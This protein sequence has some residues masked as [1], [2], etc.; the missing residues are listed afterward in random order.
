MKLTHLALAAVLGASVLAAQAHE[1]VYL[2]T[3]DGPSEAPTNNS[4]GTGTAKITFDLDLVTMRVEASFAGLTG[5]VSAA[6]IH[7]C[8]TNA[9]AGTAGV[10]TITP[11]FTG[12]PSGVTAGTYDVTF[13]MTLASSYN[14][15]F[16]NNNGGTVSSAMNALLAGLENDK[17]YFNIHTGTFPGGEIRGFLV[18]AP[19][20]E[21]ATYALMLAGMGVMGAV[22]R[23]KARRASATLV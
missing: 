10:A 3:L 17:A 6:H 13:D 1:M 9:L 5:N 11:T 19:V 18:A 14:T 8:T 20:P 12:F 2:A 16:V 23:R 21:P 7:C 22:A 15:A 4:P